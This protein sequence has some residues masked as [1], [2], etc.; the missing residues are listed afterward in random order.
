[1]RRN[2]VREASKTRGSWNY[3]EVGGLR[4]RFELEGPGAELGAAVGSLRGEESNL[5]PVR[6]FGEGYNLRC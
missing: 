3:F 1:M 6:R 2:F 5:L 4:G